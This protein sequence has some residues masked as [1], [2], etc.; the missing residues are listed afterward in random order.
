MIYYPMIDWIKCDDGV[1][2]CRD[3]AVYQ[4]E[5]GEWVAEHPLGANAVFPTE[6]LAKSTCEVGIRSIIKSELRE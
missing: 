4:I 1:Q 5:S 3:Y 6:R 2:R